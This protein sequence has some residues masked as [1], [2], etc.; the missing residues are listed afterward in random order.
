VVP[1]RRST[2]AVASRSE[3]LTRRRD[4]DQPLPG[5]EVQVI[6]IDKGATVGKVHLNPDELSTRRVLL[7][8]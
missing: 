7:G 6:R 2:S 8:P 5:G 3:P 4:S 1:R